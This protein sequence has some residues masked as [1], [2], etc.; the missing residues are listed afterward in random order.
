M[1][2]DSR[3]RAV[4]RVVW[5]GPITL[6]RSPEGRGDTEAGGSLLASTNTVILAL[7][8]RTHFTAA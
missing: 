5:E 6:S 2:G 3:T 1:S 7:D 8:A 4:A